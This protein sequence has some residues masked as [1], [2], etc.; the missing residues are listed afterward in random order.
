VL[1]IVGVFAVAASALAAVQIYSN[2]FK[3]RQSVKELKAAEAGKR[4]ER[5]WSKKRDQLRVTLK[6]APGVCTYKLPVQGDRPRP[7]YRLEAK[8][9]ITKGT[10]KN[11]RDEAYLTVSV[12]VG[13]GNR[14][15]LR[16]FPKGR[17]YV[18]RRQPSAGGFPASGTSP[19]IRKIGKRNR[20]LLAAT[21]NELRAKVNGATL[22]TVTDGNASQ[23]DGRKLEFGVGSDA[24]SKRDTVGA[25]TKVAVSVPNP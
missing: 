22:A 5:R 6:R 2:G 7:D 15:E 21:G 25:F 13:G 24:D 12:R 16:V 11:L 19:E 20:V 8:G 10:A 23:L 9:T 4:C 14:Y 1:V 17:Q 18:L 3:S